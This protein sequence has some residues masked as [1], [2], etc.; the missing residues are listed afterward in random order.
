M[1][2]RFI[3]QGS[4]IALLVA[5]SGKSL[6]HIESNCHIWSQSSHTSDIGVIS[7]GGGTNSPS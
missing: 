1:T 4:I 7:D 2:P 6:A 3:V 5:F